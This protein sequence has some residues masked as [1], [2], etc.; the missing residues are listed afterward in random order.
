MKRT[1][2]ILFILLL[3][4][5]AFNPTFSHANGSSQSESQPTLEDEI[6]ELIDELDLKEL[7]NQ[8]NGLSS[9]IVGSE[10]IKDKLVKLLKGELTV[11][12]SSASNYVLS[13]FLS[14]IKQKLPIFITLFI[15]LLICA[16]INSIKPEKLGNSVYEIVHFACY[17]VIV[18]IVITIVCA[19]INQSKDS[20]QKVSKAVQSVFPI[21]L[22]LMTTTGNTSSVAVY[23]PAM[24]FISDFVV[25]IINK[26]VFP[27]ILGMLAISVISNVSKSVKLNGLL[28]F[29]SST[30]KWIIGLIATVFSLFLTVRGLNSGVYDGIAIRALKYTVNSSVPI[31]GG[32]LR[33][34][35]DLILASAILVKNALGG[36]AIILI[37]GTI[38]KPI[39]EIACV[40]L[41]LKL[42]NAVIEPIE[43]G[44]VS[45]LIKSVGSVINF[46]IASIIIVALMY[47]VIII[48]AICSTQMIF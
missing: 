28:Q 10:S 5:Y 34:G 31:V 47:V 32:I 18:C 43:G 45:S 39:I 7:E 35:L 12:F 33:D 21:M 44:R 25:I 30:L 15:L 26:L 40:S 27:I 42:V 17:S 3:I 23:N 29:T 19:L 24:L 11:D 20:I 46:A 37:F 8:L 41:A 13:I 4:P 2:L 9:E 16:I 1:F 14:G 38:I 36:L 22:A 6:E 48:L